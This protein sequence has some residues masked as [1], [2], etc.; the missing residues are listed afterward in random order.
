MGTP[1]R[2]LASITVIST[3]PQLLLCP[4]E[5]VAYRLRGLLRPDF[6]LNL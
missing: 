2:S 6:S 4:L 1:F 3:L 5:Q